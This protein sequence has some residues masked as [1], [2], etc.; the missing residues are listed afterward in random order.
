MLIRVHRSSWGL[1][2]CAISVTEGDAVLRI[3]ADG[4]DRQELDACLRSEWAGYVLDESTVLIREEWLRRELHG[5]DEL[6][7]D[8]FVPASIVNGRGAR[9]R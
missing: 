9:G 3:E 6:A 4:L 5:S 2:S 8:E 7:P 1:A